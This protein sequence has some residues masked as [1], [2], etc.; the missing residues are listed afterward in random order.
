MMNNFTLLTSDT[1]RGGKIDN[2]HVKEG[3]Q[4]KNVQ[5]WAKIMGSAVHSLLYCKKRHKGFNNTIILCTTYTFDGMTSFCILTMY[6][7]ERSNLQ[8]DR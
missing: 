3:S 7:L 2:M 5:K 1:R 6:E 8:S 4:R